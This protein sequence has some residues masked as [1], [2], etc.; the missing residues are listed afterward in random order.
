MTTSKK[1]DTIRIELTSAQS[2]QIKTETGKAATS[3]ELS[4]QDLEERVTPFF[5]LALNH[6]ETLLVD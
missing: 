5:R 6:N 2:E 3:I 4:V 1:N